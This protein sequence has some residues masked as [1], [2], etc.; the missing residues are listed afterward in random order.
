M[1]G[2]LFVEAPVPAEERG[3]S[4]VRGGR[5][6]AAFMS[7]AFC[8]TISAA[9]G[10]ATSVSSNPFITRQGRGPI[11]VGVPGQPPTI[12]RAALARAEADARTRRSAERPRALP[13]VEQRY[14]A[15]RDA[16]KALEQS[17]S[18]DTH[19]KVAVAYHHLRVLDA[20]FD[21]FSE[22]IVLDAKNAAAWDGRARVWRDWGFVGPALADVHRARF[23][24]PDRADIY[25]TLGTILERA[26]QCESA[27]HA[28]QD[29]LARDAQATWAREN[30][31]RLDAAGTNCQPIAPKR[32]A[33]V[34]G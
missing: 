30:L 17:P 19:I 2:L 6:R 24:G 16:L 4:D 23:F 18:A 31:T 12:D 34:G 5:P 15:L 10:C 32:L 29:A 14:P 11:E 20:A 7:A 1:S 28:Y 25:N 22:A 13:S 21:H 9:G 26:G 3:L 27:R 33:R 8:L